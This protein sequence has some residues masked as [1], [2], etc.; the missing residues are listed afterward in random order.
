MLS[1]SRASVTAESV[2]EGARDIAV[3]QSQVTRHA[4]HVARHVTR[5]TSHVTR[6]TSHVTRHTSHVT[7]HTSHVTRHTS[8]GILQL[9]KDVTLDDYSE[10]LALA[11][12]PPA[13]VT[14]L[15]QT[16]KNKAEKQ[17]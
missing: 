15:H 6:H 14:I 12:F 16:F 5:H 17:H 4:S 3:E 1:D 8:H 11:A 9:T 2:P 13:L 10:T 7:R